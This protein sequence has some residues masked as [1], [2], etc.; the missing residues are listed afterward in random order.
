MP[1]SKDLQRRPQLCLPPVQLLAI[2]WALV[3]TLMEPCVDQVVTLQEAG[4]Y[5]K[6]SNAVSNN[7]RFPQNFLATLHLWKQQAP[8]NIFSATS[9]ADMISYSLAQQRPAAM[10]QG[11][12]RRPAMLSD[13]LWA[14]DANQR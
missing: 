3:A 2:F 8:S 5:S 6:M 10:A 14:L 9:S 11:Q 13:A 12:N 7:A 4:Q 1:C